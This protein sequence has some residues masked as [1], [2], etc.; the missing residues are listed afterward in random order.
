MSAALQTASELREASSPPERRGIERDAVKTL[1]TNRQQRTHLHM[2]FLDLPS[3][4]REGDLLV[5]NNSATLPAA[6][7]TDRAN[8][9]PLMLHVST[10]IDHRL[11]MAEPRGRVLRGEKLHLAGGGSAVMIAPVDPRRPRVWYASFALPLPMV[12]YLA[13]FGKPIRYAYVTEE[14]PLADYQSIFAAVPGSSEMPSA[15]RAFTARVVAALQGRGIGIATITLH[16]G[17]SSFEASEPP[18]AERYGV[19][20][21]TA[22]AVNAAKSDGRRVVAVGTTVVRALESAAHDGKVAAASGWTDLLIDEL[23]GVTIIDGLLTGFHDTGATHQWMLRAVADDEL[24]RDAY[25]EA[26]AHAYYQHEFGD[27]HLIL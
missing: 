17:V 9:E 4:L 5:V 18:A 12:D 2:R 14:F 6:L 25:L 7:L 1:V 11:W 3:V 10:M 21:E 22:A 20:I 15:A 13:H 23:R 27:V 26:A 24:L 8:G 16:C 19:S